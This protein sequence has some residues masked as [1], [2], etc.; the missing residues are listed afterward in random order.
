MGE[1]KKRTWG[2]VR[3]TFKPPTASATVCARADLFAEYERL[4]ELHTRAVEADKALDTAAQQPQAPA[5]AEQIAAL[6]EQMQA[7]EVTFTFRGVGR[8]REEQLLREHPATD[9]QQETA[10]RNSFHVLF[11]PDTYFPA[12]AAEACI[13]PEGIDLAE[14][15]R[16][17]DEWTDGQTQPLRV[18]VFT[19]NK[20]GA[21]VP[22][23]SSS[24]SGSTRRGS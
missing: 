19:V 11:N 3:D 17:Y 2:E 1:G 9:A 20:A 16:I 24:D 12:L 21:E 8:R 4:R 5:L 18:A 14:W 7:S 22:K 6:R 15:Q 23:D 13:E 10:A